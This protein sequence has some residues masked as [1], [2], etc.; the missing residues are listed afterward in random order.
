ML[1]IAI[2]AFDNCLLFSIA[3]PLDLFT[4]ANWEKRSGIRQIRNPFAGGRL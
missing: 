2:L 4:V 3:G 1:N